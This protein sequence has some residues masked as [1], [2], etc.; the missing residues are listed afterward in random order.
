MDKKLDEELS[1]ETKLKEKKE[2]EESDIM[3]NEIIAYFK[4]KAQRGEREDA[5]VR[6]SLIIISLIVAQS[7]DMDSA[8]ASVN[9]FTVMMKS[10]VEDFDRRLNRTE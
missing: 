5:F 4:K 7:K 1:E 10:F 3:T 9:N 6:I 2:L 8:Y